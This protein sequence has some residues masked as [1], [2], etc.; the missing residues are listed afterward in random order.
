MAFLKSVFTQPLAIL[1]FALVLSNIV[2]AYFMS[3]KSFKVENKKTDQLKQKMIDSEKRVQVLFKELDQ[4]RKNLM[5]DLA[6]LDKKLEEEKKKPRNNP[7]R[8]Q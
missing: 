6:S 7:D 8:G 2:L 3:K 1:V 5:R 4:N